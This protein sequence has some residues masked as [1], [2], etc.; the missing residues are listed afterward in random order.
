MS[1]F[2]VSDV[3]I[4][5]STLQPWLARDA[6]SM[7]LDRPVAGAASNVPVAFTMPGHPFVSA[8]AEAFQSHLPLVLSPDDVWL[9]IAQAAGRHIA[10]MP[11]RCA[12]AW[13]ITAAS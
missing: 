11:S 12:T 3:P 13:S 6:V 7:R 9:C 4:G 10:R 1:T 5:K 8:V 2:V